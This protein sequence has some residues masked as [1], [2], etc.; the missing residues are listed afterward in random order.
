MHGDFL[1]G[2]IFLIVFSDIGHPRFFNQLFG[3]LDQYSLG[4][5][6]LTETLNTSQYVLGHPIHLTYSLYLNVENG[7][8]TELF[9]CNFFFLYAVL[10][11][12]AY[13]SVSS[14]YF[15]LTQVQKQKMKLFG[16]QIKVRDRCTSTW[17]VKNFTHERSF[18]NLFCIWNVQE[19]EI[20][21][22]TR[23]WYIFILNGKHWRKMCMEKFLG[24]KMASPEKS[25]FYGTRE[26]IGD[27]KVVISTKHKMK[28]QYFQISKGMYLFEIWKWPVAFVLLL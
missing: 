26:K 4:G 12:T 6:W 19:L 17:Y 5:A 8:Q 28:W 23:M 27:T 7:K 21:V 22:I 14:L 25:K 9:L 16:S 20:P 24:I 1:S 13:F 15:K 10:W 11:W 3:G 18:T 2:R